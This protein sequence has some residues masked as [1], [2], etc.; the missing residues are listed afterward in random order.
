MKQTKASK[1]HQQL[2]NE[3]YEEEL[4]NAEKENEKLKSNINQIIFVEKEEKSKNEISKKDKKA[5][6]RNKSRK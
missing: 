6:S 1:L 5:K 4:K 3:I 2:K